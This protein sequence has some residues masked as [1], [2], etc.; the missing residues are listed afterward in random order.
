MR[1]ACL[2]HFSLLIIVS[3]NY[4]AGAANSSTKRQGNWPPG[5]PSG[6]DREFS[7]W[8]LEPFFSPPCLCSLYLPTF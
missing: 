1:S 8:L 5:H 3:Y 6:K 4:L 2:E 7:E